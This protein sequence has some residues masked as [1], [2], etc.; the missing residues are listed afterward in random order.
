MDPFKEESPIPQAFIWRRLHSL[1][2]LF[3]VLFLS[4]H[5]LTN[6]KAALWIGDDG[7]GFIKSVNAIHDLPY[8]LF[9]EIFLLGV[10]FAIHIIWGIKYLRTS[11]LNSFKTDGSRPYLPYRRNKAYSWQRITSWILLV[12]VI[13]HVFNMRIIHY[14]EKVKVGDQDYYLIAVTEDQGMATLLPRLDAALY[15]SP[16]YFEGNIK[17]AQEA[18]V[19]ATEQVIHQLEKLKQTAENLHPKE[20]EV[21][22]MAKDFGTADLFV[23]RDAFK[24][25]IESI[26]YSIF[27]MAASYHAFNGLW[28]FLISWG[29]IL[30]GASQRIM[31]KGAVGL[32]ILV[33]FLGLAAAWGTYWL[34]LYQ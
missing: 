1:T 15:P 13:A 11:K 23:V 6:S 33:A 21:I 8:L 27:V 14:P 31:R 32:I 2:G 5:L 30:T 17:A 34:N 26:L 29:V 7:V 19:P 18:G 3:L 22:V 12:G 28:T 25:P 16:W 4:Q 20:N 9:I 24:S 10:P